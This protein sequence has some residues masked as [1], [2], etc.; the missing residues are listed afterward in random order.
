[1]RLLF[2]IKHL[3]CLI[4]SS[5]EIFSEITLYRFA[6]KLIYA[7]LILLA[8]CKSVLTYVPAMQVEGTCSVAERSYA[9]RIQP[10]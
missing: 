9:D 5:V 2:R 4:E 1:M 10:A 3:G 7:N 6:Q 8:L